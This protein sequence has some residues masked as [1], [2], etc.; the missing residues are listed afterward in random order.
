M[1][2]S[3]TTH[4][5]LLQFSFALLPVCNSWKKE[6]IT[7]LLQSNIFNH[8]IRPDELQLSLNSEEGKRVVLPFVVNYYIFNVLLPSSL[9]IRDPFS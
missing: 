1:N 5:Y 8:T 3:D 2:F 7:S 6:Q 9:R 4:S